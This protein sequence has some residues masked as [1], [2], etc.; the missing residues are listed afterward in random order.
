MSLRYALLGLLSQQPSSGYDLTQRFAEGIGTYAWHAQHSQ[1]YPELK[2]L[3]AEELIEVTE[4][5]ARGRKTYAITDTGTQALREWLL[6]SP[7]S[8]N[9][10]NEYLLRLFLLS[11]L[12]R[13][14]AEQVLRD[15]IADSYAQID[16]LHHEVEEITRAHGH[17]TGYGALAAQYGLRMYQATID[18]AEWAIAEL[19]AHVGTDASG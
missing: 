17:T 9:T 18:W 4:L 7:P 3:L 2:R 19:H 14:D 12:P 11:A 13:H 6:D 10:R 15:T 16:Q 5:G 8:T 1:I